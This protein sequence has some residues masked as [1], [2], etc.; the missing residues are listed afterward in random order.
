MGR[1]RRG[2]RQRRQRSSKNVLVVENCNNSSEEEGEEE[3]EEEEEEEG[4]TTRGNCF[5]LPEAPI[6]YPTEE[7]FIDPL[8]FIAKIRQQVEELYGICR[9]VPPQSWRPPFALD[10][11]SFSFPT[12][13]QAIHQLQERPAACDADTFKLEYRRYLKGQKRGGRTTVEEE[14]EEEE[15]HNWP[16]FEGEDLD[17]CK[18][19]NAVKRHGGYLKVRD[20]NRWG[21]VF[22][23][24]K[25]DEDSPPAVPS[26][27]AVLAHLCELYKSH[28]YSYEVYQA[29]VR[30]GKLVSLRNPKTRRQQQKEIREV[31]CKGEQAERKR[32]TEIE[33]GVSRKRQRSRS[34]LGRSSSSEDAADSKKHVGGSGEDDS[35]DLKHVGSGGKDS[36]DPH[37]KP[38]VG[39]EE[40]NRAVDQ[41]CK[42]CHSGVH[43][44]LMLLCARCNRGWHLYCL[45][46]PL[47][48]APHGNWYCLDCVASSDDCFGFVPG[49]EYSYLAFEKMAERF[50]HKWFGSRSA[51]FAN[52]EKELWQIVERATAPV[53]VLYGSD[54]DTGVYGSG[55]PRESEAVMWTSGQLTLTTHGISTTSQSSGVPCYGWCR[56]ISLG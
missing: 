22:R 46:P 48:T 29:N 30:S 9:I 35:S 49:K 45:S 28:L 2:T 52:V 36:S 53:E 51:E 43:E 50:K 17:L 8:R 40:H 11:S 33:L 32:H 42:Q 56:T 47:S 19:F 12:K 18:L 14:E 34:N 1:R 23:M 20:E 27:S 10:S 7:E 5:G 24:L 25:S 16:Q 13:I 21:E 37:I 26:S 44:K 55:F 31:N 15:D 54:I 3:E 39:S 38:V 6:F 41:I 4:R